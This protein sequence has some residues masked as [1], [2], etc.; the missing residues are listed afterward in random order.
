MKFKITV[1]VLLSFLLL[2]YCRA[3]SFEACKS[4]CDDA[5][6][7]AMDKAVDWI[8]SCSK[9]EGNYKPSE[10]CQENDSGEQ[11]TKV[12]AECKRDDPRE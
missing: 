12:T 10:R 5:Q 9:G 11:C 3:E 2:E 8:Q 7:A 1:F 6:A 4:K